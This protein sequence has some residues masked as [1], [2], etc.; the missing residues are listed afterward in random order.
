MSRYRFACCLAPL[1]LVAP[2]QGQEAPLPPAPV[3]VDSPPPS[4]GRPVPLPP[5]RPTPL[6]YDPLP[7]APV[8]V[9]G[10]APPPLDPGPDGWGPLGTSSQPPGWFLGADVAYVWPGL[11]FRVTNDIPLPNN[12]FTLDLPNVSLDSTVTPTFEVGYRLGGSD[13]LFAASYSFLITEGTGKATNGL[14]TFDVK[15]RAQV[16]WGDLDYGAVLIDAAP[17]WDVSWRIGARLADVYFDSRATRP[18]LTQSASNNF[19]GGGPHARLD[20]ERRIIPVP[21][22]ALYGRLDGAVF[23][24]FI[25]QDYQATVGGVSGSMSVNNRTQTVPYLNLQA[26]LS[27]APPA[28]PGLKL[29]AGYTFEDYFNVG[30]LGA[31]QDGVSSSRGELWWQGVFV[32]GQY[33]F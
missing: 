4:L 11:K 32:R 18:G 17:H 33:D 8:V 10:V 16:N 29:T 6:T 21:G 26:G 28:L 22:L 23:V 7:P 14:G 27:Y 12:G 30:R 5:I 3:P 1:L 20:V 24:G 13:G 9:P 15:T 19:F 31:D 25:D 2:L